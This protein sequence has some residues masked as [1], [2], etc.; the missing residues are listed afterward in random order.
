MS[1]KRFRLSSRLQTVRFFPA[2]RRP[3]TVWATYLHGL[4]DDDDFRRAYIDRK[5]RGGQ[6]S[7]AVETP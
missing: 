1:A 6:A 7:P 3:E 5:K 2:G 4:F